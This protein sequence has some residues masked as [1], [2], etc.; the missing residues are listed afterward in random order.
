MVGKI[1]ALLLGLALFNVALMTVC[2]FWTEIS[3]LIIT[4]SGMLLALLLALGL[5]VPL[6]IIQYLQYRKKEGYRKLRM[7]QKV[8][9]AQ[10]KE[11][12]IDF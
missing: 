4:P 12:G 11:V 7:R 3:K 1:L 2:F 8:E 5:S 9:A 10:Q 6:L